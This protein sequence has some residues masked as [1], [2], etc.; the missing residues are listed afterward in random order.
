MCPSD[1]T[2]PTSDARARRTGL[3]KDPER[4]AARAAQLA[5]I[6]PDWNCPW[7]L[8]WQRHYRVLA[9]L[10]DADGSLPHIAPG[11]TFEGDDIGTWRW[12][13][14]E[15]GIW[16][17]LLPEQRDRLEALG[18]HGAT[19][20][21][22]AAAPAE[23]R[24]PLAAALK[25]PKKPG[26]KA[27]AAF[28]CGLAAL[29]QW[30]ER[31]GPERPVPRAHSEEIAVDSETEPVP[32][33]LG[34]WLSNTKSQRANLTA[35]QLTVLGMDWAGPPPG[36]RGRSRAI[37]PAARTVGSPAAGGTRAPE[38]DKVALFTRPGSGSLSVDHH[39]E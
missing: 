7:P 1:S 30:V 13:Q 36:A 15:P 3:A 6:D 31:E 29:T 26:R 22:A 35:Q 27:E 28:Q 32:V 10:V 4:A 37:R 8:N 18:V 9:D 11:V 2:W 20:P 19:L 21:G 5:E 12:R 17:Q 39:A 25:G 34:V 38:C 14:Q 24:P 33:K 16:A 23:L